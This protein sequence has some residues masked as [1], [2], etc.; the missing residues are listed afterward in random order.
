[1]SRGISPNSLF[2]MGEST[3]VSAGEHLRWQE[4]SAQILTARK[5]AALEGFKGQGS[6]MV[7]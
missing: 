2:I 4:C 5:E 1:M 7:Q 6:Q 3:P